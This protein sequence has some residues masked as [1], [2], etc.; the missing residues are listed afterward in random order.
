MLQTGCFWREFV[1][2]VSIALMPQ[3]AIDNLGQMLDM[4]DMSNNPLD[5][6]QAGE[7]D[8]NEDEDE[9]GEE[10]E[11]E[12]EEEE[13][14][15]EDEE[16]EEEDEDEELVEEDEDEESEEEDENEEEAEND[17]GEATRL[18]MIRENV[19]L[20][21]INGGSNDNDASS[22]DWN[23]V[24]EAEGERLNKALENAL[25]AFKPKGGKGGGSKSKPKQQTKS[26]RIDS[27]ALLHFRIRM[28]DLIELFAH[29]Q[30]NMEVISSIIIIIYRICRAASLDKNMKPLADASKKKLRSLLSQPITNGSVA[31]TETVILEAIEQ[32]IA[33]EKDETDEPEE[34]PKQKKQQQQQQQ[35]KVSGDVAELHNKCV[36]YLIGQFNAANITESKVWPVVETYLKKW[37]SRRN[38][39]YTLGS[40]DE[41]FKCNWIGSPYLAISFVNHLLAKET[42]QFRRKQILELLNKH[43]S[44]IRSILP[45][46]ERA[47]SELSACL[48]KYEP[49][50]P[51][52]RKLHSK[53]L[54]NM[55]STLKK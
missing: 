42:R 32:F 15:R 55:F 37:V 34:Q 24:D 1:K 19:R 2:T 13:E 17:D 11:D 10:D 14:E 6:K 46:N 49:A 18:E 20:A 16:S 5:K 4:L 12:D 50:G 28:L 26:E 53:L 48:K 52:D 36:S 22:V 30:P 41:L 8:Y 47:A 38:S 23:D 45:T 43:S 27:T 51:T 31:K 35:P 33:E 9:D 44:R 39:P 40:F 21:L 3:L 54:T 25:Q 29:A 7:E